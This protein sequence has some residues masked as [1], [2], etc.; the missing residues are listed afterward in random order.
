MSEIVEINPIN[1]LV[2]SLGKSLNVM[3]PPLSG[4][5]VVTSVSFIRRP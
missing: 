2:V 1:S 4:Y 3:S 5:L